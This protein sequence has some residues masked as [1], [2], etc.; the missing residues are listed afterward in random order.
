MSRGTRRTRQRRV[1]AASSDAQSPAPRRSSAAGARRIGRL[2]IALVQRV[3][4]EVDRPR[5]VAPPRGEYVG[6]IVDDVDARRAHDVASAVADRRCAEVVD[7]VARAAR[8]AA[9]HEVERHQ[10]V[11]DRA[12][13]VQRD[14]GRAATALGA[15]AAASSRANA[16]VPVG[17]GHA[18][19][20][21]RPP[22]PGE[23]LREIAQVLV[24]P[25]D[26]PR[27][28]VRVLVA[29]RARAAS[30]APARRAPAA[31]S[32]SRAR[33]AAGRTRRYASSIQNSAQL[34]FAARPPR[35]TSSRPPR[36]RRP[37]ARSA[38]CTS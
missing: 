16:R 24:A 1:R 22:R 3:A 2:R 15:G 31:R 30:A 34:A 13:P 19:P 35:A 27:R 8:R 36:R 12:R 17:V 21:A 37:R 7:R 32:R 11:A 14:G 28:L 20:V 18:D 6:R 5:V 9:R 10:D 25:R 33:S 38:P 4:D 23:R 26:E 29:S